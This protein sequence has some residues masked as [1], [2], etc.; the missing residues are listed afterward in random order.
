MCGI[1]R[2]YFDAQEQIVPDNKELE[3]SFMDVDTSFAD[4]YEEVFAQ[5][6]LCFLRFDL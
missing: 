6:K 1:T 4:Y 5:E 3:A 2:F